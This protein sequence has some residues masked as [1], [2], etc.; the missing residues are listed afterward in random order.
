MQKQIQSDQLDSLRIKK[1]IIPKA[2]AESAWLNH[3]N[4]YPQ[5]V[6]QD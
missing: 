5:C 1:Y 6:M 3:H 4:F 2:C